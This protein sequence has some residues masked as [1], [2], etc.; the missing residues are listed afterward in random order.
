[1]LPKVAGCVLKQILPGNGAAITG[2]GG[3]NGRDSRQVSPGGETGIFAQFLEII[4]NFGGEL[5][6]SVF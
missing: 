2:N 5:P 3:R 6:N 4:E 1:M